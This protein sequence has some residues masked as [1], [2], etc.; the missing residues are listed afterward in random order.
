M[1]AE[2]VRVS[3]MKVLETAAE[4]PRF[5]Y[6][7]VM[8]APQ[9]IW[10]ETKGKGVKIAVIDTGVDLNHPDLQHVK[11]LNF[12]SEGLQ[13]GN[14][15]GTWCCGAIAANGKMIGIAPEAEVFS[16]K[17]MKND[18]T[19]NQADIIK[20]LEW[21]E[22]N[23]IDVI[24]MSIGGGKPSDSRYHAVVKRLWE[25]GVV[26][27]A[28]ASNWGDIFPDE[29]TVQ[30]P[31]EYDEVIAVAAVNVQKDLASFSSRGKQV[32]LAAAGV[33]VWGCWTGGKYA[34]VSGTSM[35]TPEIAAAAGLKQGQSVFRL[36]RKLAPD[37]LRMHMQLDAEDRGIKG[38]DREYGFG[39]FSF[40]R[41]DEKGNLA[42]DAPPREI[43][44]N[45]ATGQF[46]AD[47]ELYRMDVPPILVKGRTM[48]E[49]RGL[50]T[51]LG[52]NQILWEPPMAIF[53][54]T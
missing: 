45:T 11:A 8:M 34:K 51:A 26:L 52:F 49:I 46:W 2:E 23:D 27:V 9:L 17:A 44:V 20:A 30:Y 16:L 29:D 10:P 14:G 32:E 43:K 41:F 35:A 18:G 3:E 36:G 37:V 21:C 7:T 1:G 48:A 42:P 4:P 40:A 15:H 22:D 31:A 28:A 54:N 13:D 5:S 50:A 47:G 19:G 33:E 6:A 12:T 24:S 25:K 39:V 53:R 38:R